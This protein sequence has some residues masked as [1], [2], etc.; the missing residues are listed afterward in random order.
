MKTL[1]TYFSQT[2]NTKKVAE[3]IYGELKDDKQI[4]ELDKVQSLEGYDLVFFGFP[5]HGFG[6]AKPAKEFLVSKAR[7]KKLALFVTHA[8]LEDA[9][10]LP[11]WLANCKQPAEGADL[12]GFFNCQ[13]ELSEQVAG[14]MVK[15]GDPKLEAWGKDR[16]S[17]IGQPDAARLEKARTFARE[18]ISRNA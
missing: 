4:Q 14:F 16:P 6:P 9:P 15:S 17:T 2:G 7:G 8:S 1:V 3:A 11:E 10:S 18:I 13:G 5:M 12:I